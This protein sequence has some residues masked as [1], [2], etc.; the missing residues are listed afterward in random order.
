MKD[1]LSIVVP[2]Y[3]V[4]DYIEKCLDSIRKQTYSNFEVIMV[5]DGSTDQSVEICQEY[6]KQDKRFKYYKKENGG[7][8]DARNFGLKHISGNYIG[9]VDSDEYIEKEMFSELMR[10]AIEHNADVVASKYKVCDKQYLYFQ[11]DTYEAQLM[12]GYEM[13]RIHMGI[14]KSE[15]YITN[16]VWDRVYKAELLKDIEFEK[17]KNYEDIVFTALVFLKAKRCVYFDY[18]G[19]IYVQREGSIMR[20]GD[21]LRELQELP[22]QLNKRMAI[23]NSY[24]MAD[25]LQKCAYDYCE[26]FINR[27]LHIN[28]TKELSNNREYNRILNE[29]I[30]EHKKNAI[31]Y[32]LKRKMFNK[33]FTINGACYFWR[34][35][36]W[37]RKFV[38]G[39]M[40]N[41][42]EDYSQNAG[43]IRK[44][45]A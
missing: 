15:C 34:I 29:K 19:Y 9:F 35:Y 5:D 17:G 12:S 7:L 10:I 27:K 30:R 40:V 20:N 2:V 25:C 32:A 31:R 21:I 11:N 23:F 8:A 6:A 16:S 14:E 33:F 13:L 24:G 43:W 44:P 42:K 38:E 3:N 37:M 41:E 18:S 1:K 4:Q 39:I 22:Y 45:N 28:S 26:Y 36:Q